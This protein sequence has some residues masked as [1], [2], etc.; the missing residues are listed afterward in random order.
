METVSPLERLLDLFKPRKGKDLNVD[1]I[2][3]AKV[4]GFKVFETSD[5]PRWLAFSS[6]AFLD[7]DK[8]LFTTDALKEA[9]EYADKTEERGPLRIFHVEG[10]DVG[11]TDFQDVV[12]RFLVESGTF[13]NDEI[14]QSAVKYFK[15]HADTPFQVSIGFQYEA[16]DEEDGVYDWLRVKERSVCPFGEAAN[17]YTTFALG[18]IGGKEMDERKMTMLTD[19]FGRDLASRIVGKAE[20]QTKELEGSVAYKTTETGSDATSVT[21]EVFGGTLDEMKAAAQ[22]AVE[23]AF[24]KAKK[25]AEDMADGGADD[26][27]EKPDGTPK[28]PAKKEVEEEAKA[29][30]FEPITVALQAIAER[31]D[32][33]DTL[34][35]TVESLESQF[36][37][38]KDK[39][40]KAPKGREAF[41]AS[42]SDKNI[43]DPDKLKELTGEEPEQPVNP[44]RG[45]IEDLAG[46]VNMNGNR[47]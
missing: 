1:F 18:E 28:K 42:E 37:E 47:S 40:A 14:G 39:D 16:G 25:P 9:V 19:M 13:R 46:M 30:D 23:E 43:L 27:M 3:A 26:N 32:G 29:S 10:A 41:R 11:D 33:F 20:E 6:N 17:P 21:I 15:D 38:F 7:L 44:I 8:E 31:L 4:S 36:K 2:D 5:G 22:A 12:G 34:K 24:A 35:E 45:Y